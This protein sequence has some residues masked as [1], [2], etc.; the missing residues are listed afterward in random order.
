LKAMSRPTLL[1]LGGQHKGSPY[2]PL[3]PLLKRTVKEVLTIGES[4]RIISKDLKKT[5]PLTHCKTLD[6]AVHYASLMANRGDAVLLSPACASFD[7]F[8]NFEHR[9]DHFMRLVKSLGI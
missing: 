4:A 2:T 5:V 6:K 9:G 7:Q 8:N 1:I 3:I